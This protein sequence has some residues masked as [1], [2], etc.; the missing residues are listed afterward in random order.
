MIDHNVK[1]LVQIS[2]DKAISPTTV[3]GATKMLSERIA[4][5]R[6]LAKGTH[7]T[8]ISCVR[9][10]N[11]LGSRGSIIPLIKK[12]IEEGN[13]V[14]LTDINMKRFF[15]SIDQAVKLVL[16]AMVLANGGEIF[17]LKMPTILIKDLVDIIIEEYSPKIGKDPKSIK[18]EIIGP[19][20]REKLN[21]VLISPQEFTS[22]YETE[23][24]YIIY[25]DPKF[26]LDLALNKVQPN[27]SKVI[28]DENFHYSTDEVPLMH[29][30]DLKNL[31]LKLNLI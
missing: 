24:M 8:I 18:K 10:G 31:L 9:F 15:M 13:A 7:K 22:C 25:P 17:V 1:K 20:I 14:T 30:K 23:D 11:V 2:T 4:I 28:L 27:G 21:E 16:K 6:G 29:K 12:Q 3:M 19:R 5:S 26:D